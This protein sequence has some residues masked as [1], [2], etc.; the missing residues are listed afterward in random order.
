MTC[1]STKGLQKH[2]QKDAENG[3]RKGNIICFFTTYNISSPLVPFYFLKKVILGF[4]KIGL[5]GRGESREK[6]DSTSLHLN[7]QFWTASMTRT[8][9][10]RACNDFLE[11]LKRCLD[12]HLTLFFGS[13]YQFWRL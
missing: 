8:S 12:L 4:D 6:F 1:R 10:V 9:F 13:V 5:A 11:P 2:P 3:E 7:A